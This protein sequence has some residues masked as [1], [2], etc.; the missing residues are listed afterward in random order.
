MRIEVFVLQAADQF[1][2]RRAG[3]NCQFVLCLEFEVSCCSCP[4]LKV[5]D[6]ACLV[7][8]PGHWMLRT[9]V[10]LGCGNA[11]KTPI[12][13]YGDESVVLKIAFRDDMENSE[14]LQNEIRIY[15]HL[16][17]KGCDSIVPEVLDMGFDR[18]VV[19]LPCLRPI[20]HV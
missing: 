14:E 8:P 18:Q 12:P 19:L 1:S 15:R 2:G 5:C 10:P 13:F 11:R 4:K 3:P 7:K 6:Y 16:S 17:S 20:F 9:Q